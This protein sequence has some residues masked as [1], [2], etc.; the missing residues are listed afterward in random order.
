MDSNTLAL[1]ADDTAIISNSGNLNM[2]IDKLQDHAA[3]MIKFFV[4]WKIKI[5]A[6]KTELLL[7]GH[8][9]RP[10]SKKM[11]VAGQTVNSKTCVKYLG[12]HIDANL[13]FTKHI[14]HTVTKA[15]VAMNLL[16]NILR[17]KH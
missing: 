1:F 3:A 10:V 11:M 17:S 16:H 15:K 8:N 6:D 2:L 14:N 12:L 5:N 4:K 9:G 13:N 7:T